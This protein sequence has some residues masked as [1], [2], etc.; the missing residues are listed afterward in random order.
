MQK[1]ESGVKIFGLISAILFLV[2]LTSCSSQPVS[3][4]DMDVSLPPDMNQVGAFN[5]IQ[6][7]IE[8]DLDETQMAIRNENFSGGVYSYKG[9]VDV[10]SLKD[11]IIASMRN[12]KWRFDGES[13]SP[14]TT[15]LAFTKPSKSCMMIINDDFWT[16]R[17]ELIVTQNL[18][19]SKSLDPFGQPIN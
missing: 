5:D 10:A 3:S 1:R 8:M 4:T 15:V 19:V 11:F 12:N 16:T 9:K 6:L 7:P 18:T 14:E 13:V 17:V 2:V